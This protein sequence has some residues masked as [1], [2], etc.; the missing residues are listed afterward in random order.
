MLK[1]YEDFLNKMGAKI[2]G[3]GTSN[4]T[5][6]GVGY[7]HSANINVIP[8]R[9]EAGTYV[10][11]GVLLGNNLKINNVIP[12]HIESLIDKLKE[13][14]MQDGDTVIIKDIT[15]EYTE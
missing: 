3:A 5:V 9:I 11:T 4:I 1:K 12:K 7:L 10:I 13:A 8:D 2:T 15:F 14:G 6:E